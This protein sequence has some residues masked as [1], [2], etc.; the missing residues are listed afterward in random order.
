MEIVVLA[1]IGII[2]IVCIIVFLHKN[3][4]I[5]STQTE[6]YYNKSSEIDFTPGNDFFIYNYYKV[7]IDVFINRNTMNSPKESSFSQENTMN[8]LSEN[9]S[10]KLVS[11]LKPKERVGIKF[12]KIAQENII[13]KSIVTVYGYPQFTDTKGYPKP[14]LIGQ[15]IINTFSSNKTIRNL[16]L[17]QHVGYNDLNLSG[18]ITR[19]P[20]GGTTIPRLRIINNTP[21]T[22]KL[23]TVAVNEPII[24]GPNSHGL[25]F[26]Q[27]TRGIPLGI[28]FKDMD[29]Y[30]SDYSVNIPI[31]DL[32]LGLI[33]DIKLPFYNGSKY[34]SFDFSLGNDKLLGDDLIGDP[35]GGIQDNF[36]EVGNYQYHN[37]ANLNNAFIPKNW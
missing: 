33:S 1:L 30:L 20:L 31:T 14:Q 17:G 37:G 19:S 27:Y 12:D 34:G 15:S 18:E 22:I 5:Q 35:L 11:Q 2:A 6:K 16:H 9:T 10:L 23:Y 7:P 8:S 36:L 3:S 21:R 29:G 4:D 25:Y 28:T 13:N 26:G 32:H 24:I